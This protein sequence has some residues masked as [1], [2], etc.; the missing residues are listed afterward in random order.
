MEMKNES[1]VLFQGSEMENHV[2]HAKQLR[3]DA[4]AGFVRQTT[5]RLK[6]WKAH[7]SASRDGFGEFDIPGMSKPCH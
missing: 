6:A 1:N 3:A 2:E 4:I 7:K 5:A